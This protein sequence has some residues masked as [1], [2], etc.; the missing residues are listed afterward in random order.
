MDLVVHR[1]GGV[2]VH[3][4]AVAEVFQAEVGAG[5]ES[6]E[7]RSAPVQVFADGILFGFQE[8]ALRTQNHDHRGVVRNPVSQPS[9]DADVTHLVVEETQQLA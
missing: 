8:R 9:P 7:Q 2:V 5:L 6:D 1:H 4:Q 3:A